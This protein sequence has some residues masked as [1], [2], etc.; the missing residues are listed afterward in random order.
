MHPE[1]LKHSITQVEGQPEKTANQAERI[2]FLQVEVKHPRQSSKFKEEP[3]YV[4][5]L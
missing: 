3:H 5:A 2:G 1:K 4:E